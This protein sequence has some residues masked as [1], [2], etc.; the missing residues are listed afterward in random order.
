MARRTK[1]L[2]ELCDERYA[3]PDVAAWVN[4]CIVDAKTHDAVMSGERRLPS[5]EDAERN[6]AR[7][8]AE[9]A[10]EAAKSGGQK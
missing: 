5:E 10:K 2:S 4:Q 1:T 8:Q 3:D 7:V 6:Y 9:A